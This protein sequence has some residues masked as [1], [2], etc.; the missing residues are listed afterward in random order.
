VAKSKKTNSNQPASPVISRTIKPMERLL[1]FVRAGGRCQFDGCNEYLLEDALTLTEGNFSEVAHIVAFREDGPRGKDASRPAK[2]NQIDNLMLLCAKHH[3]LIDDNPEDYT[4]HSLD[5]YKRSHEERIK[6]VTGL[7]A[8]RKTAVLVFKAPIAGQTVAVPFDHVV[9]AT[10]PR[11]PMSRDP[12]TIDL[13]QI[14]TTTHEHL[15]TSC[16]AIAPRVAALFAPEGDAAKAGHVSV[17]AIGPIPCLVFLGRELTNKVPVDVFQRHRD[18]ERWTW[19]QDGP[20]VA[21]AFRRVRDGAKDKVAVAMSLS[22]TIDIVNLP[23]DVVDGA[24]VYEFTLDGATPSTSFLRTRAD[25]DAFRIAYQEFLATLLQQHGTLDSVALFPAVPAPIAVLCGRE[26]L[27]KVHPRL[28]VFDY[29][30]DRRFIFA[31]TV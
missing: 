27:P 6:H 1:L 22:G 19:K 21:Y 25:L 2:I 4:R 31:L 12:L 11:Y 23:S 3:K 26:L 8:N 10:S 13:T 20:P 14:P 5:T 29:Q 17:F 24:T 15:Q 30:R 16:D 7:G 18:T 9:E 28:R